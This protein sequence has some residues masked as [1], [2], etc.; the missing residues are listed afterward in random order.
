MLSDCGDILPDCG[1]LLRRQGRRGSIF[2]RRDA[3]CWLVVNPVGADILNLCDGCRSLDDIGTILSTKYSCSPKEAERD[4]LAF[5]SRVE[6]S[7][8]FADSPSRREY[9]KQSV[10]GSPEI[11]VTS[12]CNQ[13]CS[14]CAVRG[15]FPEGDMAARL[16]RKIVR[17][18]AALG[19]AKVVLTGGEPLLRDDL[20]D[21]LR[22]TQGIVPAQVLTNGTLLDI[23][24][25]RDL[26]RLKT[27]VQVSL[28]GGCAEVHD[29]LRGEGSFHEGIRA[30]RLLMDAGLDRVTVN[31]TIQKANAGDVS[32]LLDLAEQE[33]IKEVTFT[34][35]A[36]AV[37]GPR[38]SQCADVDSILSVK[39]CLDHYSGP[40]RTAMRVPGFGRDAISLRPW[41]MPGYSP[42]ISPDGSV[43]PCTLFAGSPFVLGN[44]SE[45][46]LEEI[47]HSEALLS[48]RR[49]CLERV[50]K[51]RECSSCVWKHFCLA[52][53]AAFSYQQKGTLLAKDCLCEVRDRLYA[54]LFLGGENNADAVQE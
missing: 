51:I 33:G 23:A 37:V 50:D 9:P 44:L 12:R 32:G 19:A 49:T 28:E 11:Y 13:S 16:F 22:D 53:C 54:D 21:L 24:T 18:A 38:R 17:E 25:A 10:L 3:P 41:C 46:S 5:G 35:L 1:R 40:V 45:C 14:Y 39:Q 43:L 31:F 29:S 6:D 34:A 26:S 8:L 2:V 36:P 7:G 52:G 42:S 48:L 20:L 15:A 27:A 30:I 4:L 47:I